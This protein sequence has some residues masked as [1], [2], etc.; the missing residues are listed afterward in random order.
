[1]IDEAVLVIM[2][3]VASALEQII[4]SK[5]KKGCSFEQPSSMVAGTG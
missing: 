4:F 3:I 2:L 1:M 5:T